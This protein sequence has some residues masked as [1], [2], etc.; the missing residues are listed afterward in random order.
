MELCSECG[1]IGWTGWTAG[2]PSRLRRVA[3][4]SGDAA[5]GAHHTRCG[6]CSPRDEASVGGGNTVAAGV[7][8][9]GQVELRLHCNQLCEHGHRHKGSTPL[10]HAGSIQLVTRAI[11]G[12]AADLY[13][14]MYNLMCRVETSVCVD[15]EA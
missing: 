5:A 1:G 10:V 8:V 11:L 14:R 4:V 12:P 15:N 2:R 3:G 6:G 7:L 9:P 13:R